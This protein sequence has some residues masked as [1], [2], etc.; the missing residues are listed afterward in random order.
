MK[1]KVNLSV[2]LAGCAS[3]LS[4]PLHAITLQL[5]AFWKELN[6]TLQIHRQLNLISCE[7]SLLVSIT[8]EL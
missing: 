3:Y 1:M 2:Y 4:S 6:P 8:M 7:S 5:K